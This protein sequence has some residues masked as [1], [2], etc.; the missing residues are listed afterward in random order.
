MKLNLEGL[1]NRDYIKKNYKLP[2]FNIEQIKNNTKLNP[3]WIHFGAGNIFRAYPARLHQ[4]LLNKG[5]AK[6][7]IIVAEGFDYEIIDKIFIPYDLLTLSVILKANGDI[8]KEVVASVVE[9]LKFDPSFTADFKRL[10]EVFENK[11][12]Q[13]ASFTITEKGYELKNSQNEY[14]GSVLHD[15]NEGLN[16]PTSYLGKVTHLLFKRYLKGKYPLT[17]VSMDN[18]SHNGTKLQN[19]ILEIANKWFE[20]KLVDKGFVDYLTNNVSYPWSMIDKITPRPDELVGKMLEKEGFLDAQ[21]LITSKNTYVAPYVNAEA[22]EYLIIEDN[23]KNGRPKLDLAGVIFTD[24]ETVDKVEKMK[25][26]T[27][28][29][30]L[31]TALAI[32]GSLLGFS[33]ISEQMKDELMVKLVK[34]IGYD[35]GL[36]VVVDPKI[37]NPKS[38]IDEVI[39]TRF[40]NPFM[41]DT[42]QRIATDTSQKLAIRYGVTILEYVK[43]GNV[44][45]LKII[46]LVLAGWIRYLMGIDDSGEKFT[47]SPDPLYKDL[48]EMVKDIKLGEITRLTDIENLLSNE[49]IFGVNLV[50]IGLG[51]RIVNYLNELNAGAGSIKRTLKK[52]LI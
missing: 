24:K 25:V 7:G 52:Y 10:V 50:K 6:T 17:L 12:L 13:I 37:I 49:K 41:P 29:N 21:A 8:E 28:L 51:D 14:F 20:N 19:S 11:S 3:E 27:C 38:F 16:V 44:K 18:Y 26:T 47:I 22:T 15:F 9:A 42:P 36:P 5:H 32:Y 31:H 35:E 43:N 34:K 40:P 4:E 39:N 2:T 45:D 33:K 23:F 30:P 48:Y 1:K 46:P